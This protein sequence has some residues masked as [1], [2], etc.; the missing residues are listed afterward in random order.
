MFNY[1]VLIYKV[2]LNCCYRQ[3]FI[4]Y[5]SVWCSFV[6]RSLKFGA[7]IFFG[8]VTFFRASN[9]SNLLA[10]WA[11]GFKS[12]LWR[13]AF[14][15]VSLI[16]MMSNI[17]L[18]ISSSNSVTLSPEESD[19]ALYRTCISLVSSGS[20]FEPSDSSHLLLRRHHFRCL[21]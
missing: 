2:V 4:W 6:R 9:F 11:S 8:P 16:P 14:L 13:P 7:M 1:V 12:L 19:L 3:V 10:P 17:I 21:G 5:V 15:L 20:L 18:A